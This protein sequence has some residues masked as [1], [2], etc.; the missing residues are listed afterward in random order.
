MLD[1]KEHILQLVNALENRGVTQQRI[2]EVVAN[3]LLH[4]VDI[5]CWN[6]ASKERIAL[7]AF[8]LAGTRSF[9]QECLD[10]GSDSDG[11]NIIERQINEIDQH[12]SARQWPSDIRE[13]DPVLLKQFWNQN[14]QNGSKT[15]VKNLPAYVSEL[16]P[17]TDFRNE[18]NRILRILLKLPVS[19]SHKGD[20][21][22]VLTH[23]L[24]NNIQASTDR[25][26]RAIIG[27]ELQER[28]PNA[29]GFISVIHGHRDAEKLNKLLDLKKMSS[30]GFL[31]SILLWMFWE[32]WNSTGLHS[33]GIAWIRCSG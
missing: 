12:F 19:V 8:L 10:K 27:D 16:I 4:K 2:R 28:Y 23:D 32:N 14:K 17:V 20:F 21:E 3:I 26:V 33:Y 24:V 9:L 18:R 25:F 13:D 15:A 6:E 29:Y 22:P 31:V 7:H 1:K 5:I 11:R 30:Q